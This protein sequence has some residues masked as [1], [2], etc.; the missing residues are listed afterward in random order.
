MNYVFKY[1]AKDGRVLGYHLSTFCQVGPKERAKVYP[2]STQEKLQSQRDVILRNLE[3][4]LAGRTGEA[5]GLVSVL[6]KPA[7]ESFSGFAPGDVDV[8][9]EEVPTV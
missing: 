2:C 3:G 9:P 1:V 6:F 5:G 8:V 4:V 7:A